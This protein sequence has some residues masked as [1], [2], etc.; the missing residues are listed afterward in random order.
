[1]RN[2]T[3]GILVTSLV[4]AALSLGIVSGALWK[5]TRVQAE[6]V[7]IDAAY[8]G[9]LSAFDSQFETVYA[10]PHADTSVI[11]RLASHIATNKNNVIVDGQGNKAL[12]MSASVAGLVA[13]RYYVGDLTAGTTYKLSMDAKCGSAFD[14]TRSLTLSLRN[15]SATVESPTVA[16]SAVGQTAYTN[17]SQTYTPSAA[18]SHA[19]FVIYFSGTVDTA[20]YL[21]LDN[22]KLEKQTSDGVYETAVDSNDDFDC[23]TYAFTST[24]TESF[25]LHTD[26]SSVYEEEDGNHALK[27][28]SRVAS[29]GTTGLRY[30]VGNLEAG[31]YRLSLRAKKGSAVTATLF[32]ASLRATGQSNLDRTFVPSSEWS[33]LSAAYAVSA[34]YSDAYFVIYYTGAKLDDNCYLLLDDLVLE[35][36]TTD[37]GYETAYD[38][39]G[40]LEIFSGAASAYKWSSA[41]ITNNWFVSAAQLENAYVVQDNGNSVMKLQNK[42]SEEGVNGSASVTKICT[43]ALWTNGIYKVSFDLKGGSA[44]TSNNIGF[45]V[46]NSA[47]TVKYEKQVSAATIAT[48]NNDSWITVEIEFAVTASG[49][50]VEPRLD[51]WY[52]NNS[53]PDENNYLLIDNVRFEE[54]MTYE[55]LVGEDTDDFVYQGATIRLKKTDDTTGDGIRF[56]VLLTE[57]LYNKITEATTIEPV[58]GTLVIPADLKGDDALTVGTA[59]V[60]NTVT[61]GVMTKETIDGV[62]YYRWI[63]YVWGIPE[64]AYSR[65]FAV[66]G[67]INLDGYYLYTEE[68]A[69]ARSISWVAQQA[70][71]DPDMAAVQDKIVAYLPTVS[72]DV[73]EGTGTVSDVVLYDGLTYTLPE[74]STLGISAPTGKVFAGY[75]VYGNTYAVGNSVIINGTT[76]VTLIWEDN[77]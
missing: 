60:S 65:G 26:S 59:N 56:S 15:S 11:N 4:T 42:T 14:T 25:M 66:R 77:A 44:F 32:T 7:N 43:T 19:Y 55:A 23:T 51:I 40:D 41:V 45:R 73:G 49:E 50:T 17:L 18:Q 37:G 39:N 57:T 38:T 61:N 69:E 12:K 10:L 9:D 67:Y 47:S 58:F 24:K 48:I 2:K 74:F 16:L 76:V 62:T 72:F 8:N 5:E 29:N 70:Y 46:R 27:I 31:T 54:V 75:S 52:F 63:V 33:T 22:I 64:L 53:T 36:E 30:Y 6:S 1:M 34:A 68:K 13:I 3:K 21:I 20:D 35:K 71:A 28:T